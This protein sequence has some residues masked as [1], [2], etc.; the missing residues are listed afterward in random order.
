MEKDNKYLDE[1]KEFTKNYD[2]SY[3]EFCKLKQEEENHRLAEKQRAGM[4][5]PG[6]GAEE[7]NAKCM[8]CGSGLLIIEAML[9]GNRCACCAPVR[10]GF[11]L[12]DYLLSC[13]Y[14]RKIYYA[15]I[16]LI[17][18]KGAEDSRNYLNAVLGNMG[19]TDINQ[20]KSIAR[21]RA[22]LREL[23]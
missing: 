14:D 4:G 10:Y 23:K 6:S 12:K 9:Y 17:D 20:A 3:K 16:K 8:R 1:W 7:S 13:Y 18:K 15:I 5:M 22:I 19:L 11:K 21:K 2:I